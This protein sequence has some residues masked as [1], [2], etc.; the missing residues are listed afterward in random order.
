[1]QSTRIRWF[2]S[3]AAGC[4]LVSAATGASRQRAAD[5]IAVNDP[6]PLAAAIEELERRHGWV[7]TYEDPPHEFVADT[8]DVT[9]TLSRNRDPS[10]KR[11][12]LIPRGG[13]FTFAYRD[14]GPSREPAVQPTLVALLRSYHQSG[15]PGVFRLVRTG[16]VFHVVPARNNDRLGNLVDRRSQLDA[17]ITLPARDRSVLEMLEAV[18][19][20]VRAQGGNVGLGSSPFNLINQARVRDAAASETARAV[21][22]RT[23]AATGRRLSWQLLCSPGYP[24]CAFNVR[25]VDP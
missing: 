20:R 5:E 18:L 2:V 25:I 16:E 10:N 15:N 13:A 1:M 19:E 4:A 12:V 14:G 6:R 24:S 9:D 8:L 11:R 3:V 21:L 7:V 17:R 22:V 23:L